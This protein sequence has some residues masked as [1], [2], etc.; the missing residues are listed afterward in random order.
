MNGEKPIRTKMIPPTM[1]TIAIVLSGQ[2][3]K[4]DG[5]GLK[6]IDDCEQG[7]ERPGEE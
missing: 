1:R 7:R 6:G 2:E 3:L 5:Q 4:V